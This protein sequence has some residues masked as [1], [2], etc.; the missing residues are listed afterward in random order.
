MTPRLSLDGEWKFFWGQH[1]PPEA[2][3]DSKRSEA[4]SA[5]VPGN[6][7]S[8]LTP[9]SRN[10]YLPQHGAATYALDILFSGDH[11]TNLSLNLG[12][13]ATSYKLFVISEGKTRQVLQSGVI[14]LTAENSRPFVKSQTLPLA[15][16]GNNRLTLLVQV[17]NFSGGFSGFMTAPEIG[18]SDILASQA[19][20]K[21]LWSFLCL[22]ALMILFLSQIG[23][24][25]E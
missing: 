2:F 7:N 18:H 10:T 3:D 25:C 17:S 13:I 11:L 23:T 9:G 24:L 4:S 14:G 12:D 21:R 20:I 5:P 19:S 16:S 1:I 15:P 22:G 8:L 6:W